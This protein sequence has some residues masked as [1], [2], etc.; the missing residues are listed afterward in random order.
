[1]AGLCCAVAAAREGVRVALIQ[2]RPMI[3]GNASSEIRMH[4]CGADHHGTRPNARETGILEEILLEHKH[5][6]PGM[7][8]AIFDSILWEKAAF[9]DGL[10]LY[11]NT[12]V[13]GVVAEPISQRQDG[14]VPD[15]YTRKIQSLQAVQ[16]TTEKEFLFTADIF[17]D[18]TGDGFVGAQAGADAVIGRENKDQL[19]EA[20]GLDE[21]DSCTMGSSLMFKARDMGKEVPFIKPFWA[22]AYTNEDMRYRPIT[23]I[24]SGYWWI[25]LGGGAQ[26]VIE[27]GEQIRD[28]LLKAV[29]G[30]WNYIKNSRTSEGQLRFPEAAAYDLEW[31]GF[32]PGKRESRRLLGDYVLTEQDCVETHLDEQNGKSFGKPV[33]TS[34]ETQGEPQ[35]AR[36]IGTRFPDTVAYGGWPVDVHTIEGFR[37]LNQEPNRTYLMEDVYAIPYRCYYSRNVSNLMMAGRDI[38]ASHLAFASSRVMA[39]CAIGG[40]A[41][42]TAAAMA[43]QENL[44]PRALGQTCMQQ[45]QQKLIWNDCYLPSI[46]YQWDE[47]TRPQSVFA[48]SQ[49]E[50]HEAEKIL[51]PWSRTIGEIHHDWQPEDPQR[52]AEEGT[53]PWLELAWLEPIFVNQLQILFDS[54]LSKQLTPSLSDYQLAREYPGTSPTLVRDFELSFRKDGTELKNIKV[55]ENYQRRWEIDLEEAISADRIRLTILKTHG[56]NS[57][58]VFAVRLKGQSRRAG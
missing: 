40:Q 36:R 56:T 3:G 55:T 31:V 21:A 4:I 44:S 51:D 30:V 52:E 18:A 25:E 48:S 28:D 23:E 12:H 50:G 33:G 15:S 35:T 45:L 16:M 6:N 1:M 27:E 43:C 17:V 7:S 46:P 8:W 24:C 37:K 22:D 53:A 54:D 19:D 9:Q 2:N 47:N 57:P 10:D 11:L 34:A 29:Y 58:R 41:V 38:S 26:R 14:Q 42:G 49:R 39:T 13:T 5:R 20:D 32:L